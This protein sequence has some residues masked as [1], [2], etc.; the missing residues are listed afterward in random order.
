MMHVW[1]FR[2]PNFQ[3]LPRNKRLKMICRT[4]DSREAMYE[5]YSGPACAIDRCQIPSHILSV[6]EKNYNGKSP[7]IDIYTL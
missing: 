7:R 4:L 3:V 2:P 6:T 5:P 1:H